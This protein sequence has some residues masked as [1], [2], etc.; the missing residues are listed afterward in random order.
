MR[1]RLVAEGITMSYGERRLL[2]GVDLEVEPGELVAVTGPSGSGKTTLLLILAGVL[3]PDA[4]SL[5][6]VPQAPDPGASVVVGLV[7]QT[8]A[9][10]SFS[11]AAENI[12]L[13]LQARAIDPSEIER[14]VAEQLAAL[15][16]AAQRDRIV[17][18]LSGG[19][20]QRVAVARALALAPD[21]LIADEAT[22]ELDAD[23]QAIVMDQFTEAAARGAA[24]V[25]ATHDPVVAE[26][27]HRSLLL[28]EAR[29]LVSA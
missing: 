13:P 26:R 5:R 7:P 2:D 3:K 21:I 8:I 20:R 27:C 16:L 19:Q 11:S 1:A 15:G 18:E 25:L 29:L 24:V 12:A 28:D 23:N 10:S 17:T 22:A 14:R 9:L 6:H 4:G